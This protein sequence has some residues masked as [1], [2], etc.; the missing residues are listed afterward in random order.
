MIPALRKQGQ[1]IYVRPASGWVS[2]AQGLGFGIKC[3][4]LGNGGLIRIRKQIR[5]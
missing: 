3:S 5:N 1:W 4:P 2:A